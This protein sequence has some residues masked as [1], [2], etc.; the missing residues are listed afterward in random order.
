MFIKLISGWMDSE[1]N[2]Q[3][4]VV[5]YVNSREI[6]SISE[7]KP[8]GSAINLTSG[9]ILYVMESP[10]DIFGMMIKEQTDEK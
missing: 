8:S 3:D 1:N 2:I 4:K 10:Q 7:Y 6:Q 9:N 5:N